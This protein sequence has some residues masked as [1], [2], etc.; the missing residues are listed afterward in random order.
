MQGTLCVAYILKGNDDDNNFVT[1]IRFNFASSWC[2]FRFKFLRGGKISNYLQFH[3]K[4]P[5]LKLE[6]SVVFY[7]WKPFSS[8]NGVF[9]AGFLQSIESVNSYRKHFSVCKS[10]FGLDAF[11]VLVQSKYW[12]INGS[13]ITFD[14]KQSLIIY[15]NF[16]ILF[17][18]CLN[19]KFINQ[20]IKVFKRNS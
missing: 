11:L 2:N 16:P 15:K 20:V 4:M 6:D 1:K 19:K 3:Y 12:L 9:T 14:Q 5:L 13:G 7:F 18:Q 10:Y 17:R 8:Q